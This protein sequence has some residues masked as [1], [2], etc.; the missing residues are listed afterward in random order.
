VYGRMPNGAVILHH[1]KEFMRKSHDLA[2]KD[3]Q[4]LFCFFHE[5]VDCGE[6]EI[7]LKGGIFSKVVTT[8]D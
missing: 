1:Y 8:P 4:M 3:R 2:D 7:Y 5:I 6:F